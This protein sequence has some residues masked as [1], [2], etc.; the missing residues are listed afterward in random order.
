MATSNNSVKG[1]IYYIG[2]VLLASIGVAMSFIPYLIIAKIV[3]MLLS[4]NMDVSNYLILILTMALCWILR[5]TFNSISTSLS[6][7]FQLV[8]QNLKIL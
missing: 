4:K 3:G 5:V 7:Q 2:S 1:R 6:T 8:L